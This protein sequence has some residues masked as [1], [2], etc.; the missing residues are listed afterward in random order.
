VQEV[1]EG[2]GCFVAGAQGGSSSSGGGSGRNDG[3][4][5]SDLFTGKRHQMAPSANNHPPV[6]GTNQVACLILESAKTGGAAETPDFCPEFIV[7][8]K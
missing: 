3:A 2:E 8:G 5:G 7:E 1:S 4:H 6:R